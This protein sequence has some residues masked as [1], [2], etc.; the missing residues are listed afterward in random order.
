VWPPSRLI[1]F[2]SRHRIAAALVAPVVVGLLGLAWVGDGGDH[3][4]DD[5]GDLKGALT[6]AAR[7][8]GPVTP[9]AAQYAIAH[10]TGSR[11]DL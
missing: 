5:R 10:P 2:L 1:E 4:S 6:I 11:I 7:L 8:L 9:H 3:S